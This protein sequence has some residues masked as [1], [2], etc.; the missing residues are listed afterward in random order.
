MTKIKSPSENP[1]LPSSHDG[2]QPGVQRQKAQHLRGQYPMGAAPQFF[3]AEM[4]YQQNTGSNVVQWMPNPSASYDKFDIEDEPGMHHVIAVSG[5]ADSAALALWLH[6]RFPHIHFKML[7]TDTGAESSETMDFLVEIERATRNTIEVVRG[8][9]TLWSLIEKY[10]GYLPSSLSRWCTRELKLVIFNKWMKQ[11]AD[12]RMTMYVGVRADEPTR[13]AF[14]IENVETVLP[15]REIGWRRE[16][17]FQY[18]AST[19][20]VPK[21]Y[22]T[23]TRSGCTVCPF[24]RTFETV[25]LYQRLPAEFERGQRYE[26]LLPVDQRRHQPGP[27]LWKDSGIA[28]NWLGFPLPQA[29]EITRN[30]GHD[31]DLFGTRGIFA[32]CEFFFGAMPGM[33]PFIWKQRFLSYSP[34]LAGLKKQVDGRFAHLLDTAEVHD[35]TPDEVR[36]EVKFAIYYVECPGDV[37]DPDGPTG[38][39]TWQ[40]GRSYAQIRHIT[41]WVTRILHASQLA[42]TAAM[43]V[44]NQLSVQFEW[45]CSAQEGIAAAEDSGNPLGQVVDSM[46]YTPREPAIACQIQDAE[47][48]D[49]DE[50]DLKPCPMCTI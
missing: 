14:D 49:L 34:T 42:S 6:A 28:L 20:G 9:H 32:A 50:I 33:E 5:G 17:V 18:L 21:T 8:E 4:Q 38:G 2:L 48:D 25:G 36:K 29:N 13:V 12:Q 16:H 3:G 44:K 35:L 31:A 15:F 26:K 23:R 37:F 41:D 1:K 24:T 22:L 39:Y 43:H 11:F 30:R 10:K 45:M 46:W 27:A 47:S 19:I 7:M 40:Q